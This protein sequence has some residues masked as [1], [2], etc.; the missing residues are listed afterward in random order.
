MLC[1]F[2]EGN[3]GRGAR[4]GCDDIVRSVGPAGAGA[5]Q[6]GVGAHGRVKR[7]IIALFCR[8]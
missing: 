6:V 4:D 1:S 2:V 7:T 8:I 5:R 3:V